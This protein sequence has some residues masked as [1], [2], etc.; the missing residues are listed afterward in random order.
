M[1]LRT[2]SLDFYLCFIL[3]LVDQYII[4]SMFFYLSYLSDFCLLS[5]DFIFEARNV[6]RIFIMALFR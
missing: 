2:K 4:C 6:G 5:I 1:Y 3:N